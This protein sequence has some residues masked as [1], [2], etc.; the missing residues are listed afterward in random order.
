MLMSMRDYSRKALFFRLKA[1]PQRQV[2]KRDG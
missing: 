2:R 1:K